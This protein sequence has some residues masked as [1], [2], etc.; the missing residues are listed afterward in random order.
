MTPA[1]LAEC[2]AQ[3]EPP[4]LAETTAPADRDR[5]A[6]MLDMTTAMASIYY[7]PYRKTVCL[8]WRGSIIENV[9]GVRVTNEGLRVATTAGVKLLKPDGTVQA[10]VVQVAEEPEDAGPLAGAIASYLTRK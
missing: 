8:S 10:N 2:A 3:P 4:L 5:V 9:T 6:P 1:E 7:S